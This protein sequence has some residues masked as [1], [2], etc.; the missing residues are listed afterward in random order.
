[1][2]QEDEARKLALMSLLDEA[3][4]KAMAAETEAL[5]EKIAGAT[6]E[7][8]RV[9]ETSKAASL[10]RAQ[11]EGE[12]KSLELEAGQLSGDIQG[13]RRTLS[14]ELAASMEEAKVLERQIAA[15]EGELAARRGEIAGRLQETQAASNAATELASQLR[16][17]LSQR[18]VMREEAARLRARLQ[19]KRALHLHTELVALDRASKSGTAALHRKLEEVRGL[20]IEYQAELKT[21]GAELETLRAQVASGLN[22]KAAAEGVLLSLSTELLSSQMQ[23]ERSK[24]LSA[25]S[26]AQQ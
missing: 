5:K 19:E 13:A 3:K 24:A 2:G 26:P 22:A 4:I 15:K 17:Q 6:A 1:M 10:E 16:A 14:E 7:L 25:R 18:G 11:L 8:G 20:R 21:L 12:L 9:R 23:L